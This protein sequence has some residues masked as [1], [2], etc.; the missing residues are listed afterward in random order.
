MRLID[1]DALRKLYCGWIP[2]LILPEDER[3]K[4]AIETCIAVLDDAPAIE[5]EPVR[6][7]KPNPHIVQMIGSNGDVVLE[8]QDGWECPFCAEEGVK[9]YCPNCGAK[10]DGGADNG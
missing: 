4:E 7:E 1:A 3:D 5:A 10:M 2:Q 8:Y 6:H 9:N